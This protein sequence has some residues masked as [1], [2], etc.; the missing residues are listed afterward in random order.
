MPRNRLF[1]DKL[2]SIGMVE[3]GDNPDSEVAI[4]KAKEFETG[5]KKRNPPM[6]DEQTIGQLIKVK[7]DK[8]ARKVQ[9]DGAI[10][11]DYGY[12]STPREEMVTKI[13]V[14]FW[15]TD[16]GKAVA[17]LER[18][19]GKEPADQIAKGHSEAYEAL[20]RLQG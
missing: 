18:E 16:D 8:H 2:V 10:R 6:T 19:A 1:V 11:G 5:L 20:G 17:L 14:K 9:Y 13:K 3:A 12:L 7:V 15:E 4:F